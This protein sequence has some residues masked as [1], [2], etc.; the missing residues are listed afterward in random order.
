MLISYG[1]AATDATP[2]RIETSWPDLVSWL[3]QHPRTAAKLTLAEYAHLKTFPSKSPEGRR[4]HDDKT[5]PYVALADF[6]GHRRAYDTLLHSSGVPL[7]FDTGR[8]G[9]EVIQAT[10]TGTTYVAFT[11][12]AHAPD[13]QRW[14]V[15]IPTSRP[16]SAEEHAATW[17]HLNDRFLG[18]ADPAAKDAT[19]LSYLPGVCLIPEAALITHSDGTLLQPIPA[20]PPAPATLQTHDGPVPGWAGPIDDSELITI[21]CHTRVKVAERF[22]GP[23]SMAMLWTANEE[24]LAATFPPGASEE[25]QSYSRTR[26][27]AAL[28]SELAYWTGGD[29]ERVARLMRQSGLARDDDDWS[30]RKVY[31]AFAKGM[32]GRA[33]DQFHF[34]GAKPAQAN[35]PNPIDTELKEACDET[36]A[37]SVPAGTLTASQAVIANIPAGQ[38]VSMN[39]YFGY[40]PDHTYIHRP[41]GKCCSAASVDDEIGKEARQILIPTVPVHSFTWAPGY[42]ERFTLDELDPTHVGGERVWLYNEYRAPKPPVQSGDIS[43]WLNL[44]QR[45]YPDDADHIV[46]YFADAVQTP[47]HKCNHALV[48]GSGVHGIGKDTLLAPLEFAVGTK[49]FKAVK[50]SALAS[51]FNPYVRHVVVQISE[52]RDLGEGHNSLSRY[53]MYERCKDLA[54]APPRSLDC[55]EKHKGQ[56]PVLNVLRLILTTNHQ[57]D[58]LYMDPQDRRH[59]CAWSD[60][61]KMT[62][63]EAMAV[64]DWYHA[65]GLERVAHYLR[66]LDLPA[67]DWN[68]TR[69]P[70]RTP[71]WH[72]LV[73]G[74]RN[75]EDDKFADAI[76]KMHAPEWLTVSMLAEAG[77]L[78]L[79]GWLKNPGNN[80]KVERELVKAGYQRLPN[81]DDAKRGR[82]YVGGERCAVYRRSDVAGPGLL[83]RFR[84]VVGRTV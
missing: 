21:A 71:W 60:A 65:G 44:I 45:L 78:E 15:F 27:D 12:Y 36:T 23:I 52:S 50:P 14:R 3:Y 26:A 68:R 81:P 22:G 11:T 63:A 6:G 56:Y 7:D 54:A 1:R 76:E 80:R 53:E 58:G 4:I 2:Q 42:P 73:L 41:S 51:E 8:V 34:M 49:N 5:G 9:A 13:A 46:N 79:A 20:A 47:Q 25:G 57:V 67:R 40:V 37:L 55:N 35:A 69:A 82:W 30:S 28:A 75:A 70:E 48:L 18:Q 17:A 31:L 62:E 43:L 32:E 77:G 33:P 72:Q 39:D 29:E 61:P 19:R 84:G 64:W 38:S 10:L 74:G 24:W 83:S 66:T 16:M 59:Y